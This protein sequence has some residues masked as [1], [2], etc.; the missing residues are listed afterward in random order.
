MEYEKLRDRMNHLKFVGLY[1]VFGLVIYWGVKAWRNFLV[2]LA[3]RY[4]R[5]VRR[6]IASACYLM[7][8]VPIMLVIFGVLWIYGL[9]LLDVRNGPGLLAIPLAMIGAVFPGLWWWFK[10]WKGLVELGY[11][12]KEREQ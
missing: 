3:Q 12:S 8:I 5:T 11:G 1:T 10:R 4:S 6:R 7:I 9:V 2:G